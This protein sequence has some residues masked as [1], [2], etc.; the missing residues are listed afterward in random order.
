MA[1]GL[2]G[3][4]AVSV[5]QPGVLAG[6]VASAD[7]AAALAGQVASA[8]QAAALA[9]QTPV[10]GRTHRPHRNRTNNLKQQPFIQP[11]D[12][13]DSLYIRFVSVSWLVLSQRRYEK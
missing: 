12:A 2:A 8:D 4:L 6:Q 10:Q 11:R 13:R 1:R 7:Q 5:D 9:G 3:P